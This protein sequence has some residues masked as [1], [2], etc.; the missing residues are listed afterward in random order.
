MSLSP[1]MRLMSV[2][3]VRLFLAAWTGFGTG[4]IVSFFAA[5]AA[6]EVFSCYVRESG[7]GFAIPGGS[8]LAGAL[9]AAGGLPG[10][11]VGGMLGRG[12]VVRGAVG[13][14]TGCGLSLAVHSLLVANSGL[15]DDFKGAWLAATVGVLGGLLGGAWGG[16]VPAL[17]ERQPGFHEGLGLA[18]SPAAASSTPQ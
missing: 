17:A 7:S 1:W 6:L 16:V 12:P 13:G 11:L 4:A 9:G 2:V 5:W 18:P 8:V 15:E 10:G 3:L 14:V